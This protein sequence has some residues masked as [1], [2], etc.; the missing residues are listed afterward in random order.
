VLF[1]G[2]L[3]ISPPYDYRQSS[4]DASALK[5]VTAAA[6]IPY[7]VSGADELPPGLDVI[8]AIVHLFSAV[9]PSG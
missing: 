7:T 1:N 4:R 3:P 2:L 9:T 8:L 6:R 5:P